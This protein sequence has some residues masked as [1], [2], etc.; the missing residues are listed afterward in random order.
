MSVVPATHALL[1]WAERESAPITELMYAQAV[2]EGLTTWD[3]EGAPTDHSATLSSALW[4]FLSNCVSGQVQTF[5][6]K[7][8]KMNGLDA[9]RR[10]SRF[11]D[12]GRDIRLETLRNEVRTIR[13]RFVIK[14]IEE[15]VTGI[16]KFE[17]KVQ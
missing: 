16:A 7:A 15:V 17:N 10:I 12:H 11:I 9:W 14:S 4:G 1:E 8:T 13:S 6:K 3:R 2:G 5:F